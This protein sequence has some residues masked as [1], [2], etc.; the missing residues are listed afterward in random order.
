MTWFQGRWP[1]SWLAKHI[2]V[3]ELFPIVLALKLWPGY[4]KSMQLLVLCDNEAVVYAINKQSSR[5]K[6]LMS[7]IRTMTVTLMQ[8]NVVL[9]AKHVPGKQNVV[10]DSLSRFQ[11]TPLLKYGLD[12]VP[13]A[14]PMHLLPWQL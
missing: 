9:R 1:S 2:T 11:D 4:L 5:D 7:L 8:C 10:A 14:I 6:A 13:S 3:K 12:R